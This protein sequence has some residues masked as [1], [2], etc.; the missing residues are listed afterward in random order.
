MLPDDIE[1]PELEQ[2]PTSGTIVKEITDSFTDI[3]ALVQ[4]PTDAPLLEISTNTAL[5]EDLILDQ[6]P[7]EVEWHLKSPELLEVNEK[8]QS[9]ATSMRLLQESADKLHADFQ[10]KLKYDG[11]KD[12]IIDTLHAE[13]Q[14]YKSG[15]IEKLVR[16]IIMDVIE[17]IDDTRKLL[18]DI[19]LKGEGENP[20][21][22]NK[23][24]ESVPFDLEDLLY[25]HG[26]ELVISDNSTFNPTLQKAVKVVPTDQPEL[27]KTICER[28]KNG[29]EL[30]G[31]LIRHEVVTVYQFQKRDS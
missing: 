29:Y 26:I 20:V 28:L 25:K 9:M 30:E 13:L 8:L 24:A 1:R 16:P 21:F 2:D 5:K 14:G 6:A 15:L 10:S 7:L 18:R 17:V 4:E 31:K 11:H 12:K 22:L 27:D 3:D 19:K 23:I